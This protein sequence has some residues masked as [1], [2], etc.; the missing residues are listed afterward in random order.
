MEAAQGIPMKDK[1][2]PIV[3]LE[4]VD[5]EAEKARSSRF[6]ASAIFLALPSSHST[7]EFLSCAEASF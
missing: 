4:A 2:T 1:Q 5:Q 3:D 7:A 6:F